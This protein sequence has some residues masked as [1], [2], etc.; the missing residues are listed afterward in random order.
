[1]PTKTDLLT[2]GTTAASSATFTV[3]ATE[4]ATIMIIG[5]Y[6]SVEL[7]YYDGADYASIKTITAPGEIIVAPGT[8][9]VRRPLSTYAFSVDLIK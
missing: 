2:S 8:Y 9:R 6:G 1:M 7:E 4:R 3:D 5:A